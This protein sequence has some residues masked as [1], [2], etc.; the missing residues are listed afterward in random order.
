MYKSCCRYS[1]S[2]TH[3]NKLFEFVK[4][5]ADHVLLVC[6]P[7][8]QD[9]I[10]AKVA[11]TDL[12][13]WKVQK[14]PVTSLCGDDMKQKCMLLNG[15]P[16]FDEEMAKCTVQAALLEAFAAHAVPADQIGFSRHP[17][18]VYTLKA[19]KKAKAL[20]FLPCGTVTK[21]KGDATK[22]KVVVKHA[23]GDWI[24]TPFKALSD[25]DNEKTGCL[26]PYFWVKTATDEDM[27]CMEH[28]VLAHE[29]LKIP[30]IHNT[31][32]LVAKSVLQL[33][34]PEQQSNK[35]SKN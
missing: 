22:G 15:H 29:G 35:K 25:F 8:F 3:G 18:N 32:A 30:I 17:G 21:A 28:A 33:R 5:E 1:C 24:V 7:L 2:K 10:E 19:V 31:R 14:G 16:L 23:S 12:K 13:M 6:K 20:K 34:M 9:A 4:V 26:I 11:F 27:G